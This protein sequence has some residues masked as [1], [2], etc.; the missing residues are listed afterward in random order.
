MDKIQG[1]MDTLS[2]MQL[3]ARMEGLD[4]ECKLLR[5]ERGGEESDGDRADHAENRN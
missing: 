5:T 2:S 4:A 1:H 3:T